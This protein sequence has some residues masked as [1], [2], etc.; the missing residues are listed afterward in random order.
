MPLPTTP[1]V[2]PYVPQHTPQRDPLPASPARDED[3]RLEE[4]LTEALQQQRLTLYY[5][6]RV[7]LASRCVVGAEAL[8]RWPH[9]RRGMVP[10]SVFIPLAERVGLITRLGGWA[11]SAACAEAARWPR[12]MVSVN[13]SALQLADGMLLRQ[14]QVALAESGLDPGRLEIE[15]TESLLVDARVETL[16]A[17]S[18]LRDIGIGIALDDFGTGYAS[19]AAL[20]RLPLT[21][22]KLD[23]TLVRGVMRYREDTAITRAAIE[24]G[25]V[26]GLSIVAEGIEGEGQARFLAALGCDEGQSYYFGHPVTAER[27]HQRLGEPEP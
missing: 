23:R 8:S 16:L 10:P 1:T 26:L 24:A 5:Q 21:A 15:L 6:P 9:R 2:S 14:V 18:A 4:D 3:T 22:M 19:L 20:K 25:R 27:F 12:G 11:L 13:V 7:C 17:L